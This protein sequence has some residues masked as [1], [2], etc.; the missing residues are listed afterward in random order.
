MGILSDPAAERAVIAGVCKYGSDI[1]FDICD[2]ISPDTFT[3]DSNMVL[4]QCVAK[5]YKDDDKSKIDVPIILSTAKDLGLSVVLNTPEELKHLNSILKFPV[6]IVNVKKL[7]A[8]V[9]KL[10]VARLA[11]ERLEQ[12]KDQLLEV[13]GTEKVSEILSIL[14]IDFSSFLNE[15]GETTVHIADDIDAFIQNLMDNPVSQIGI[16]TGFKYWDASIGGG[17]RKGTLN[18]IGARTKV[19]KSIIQQ[20]MALHIASK[21]IPVLYL[22]T[23]MVL[24][25]HRYRLYANMSGVE[26]NDVET[27]QFGKNT[28]DKLKVFEARDKSKNIPY[29]YQNISGMPFEEHLGIM[30]RWLMKNVGF[31]DDGSAKDCVIMYDYL[32]L[33]TG[34]N[35]SE[36]MKEYQLLGFMATGL[37]NFS[38]RYKLPIVATIQ[39]NRDGISKESTDAA[40]GSDRIAW[41]CSN[42]TI[43]KPKADEEV[44]DD[45]PAQGNRKLVT[46]IC[47]HGPGLDYGDYINVRLEGSI[48]RMTEIGLKSQISKR[49]FE[50]EDDSSIISD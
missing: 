8:K 19:G 24:E 18:V 33:M 20:N 49:E 31:N 6:E 11:F 50:L 4:W 44:A 42:F 37:H 3:I 38:V 35:I 14:E 9:R 15:T 22:D 7:A 17:L 48:A 39:L 28:A 30:R 45:G 34:D 23:E 47:R 1:Y 10:Q 36:D 5:I 43:L 27:G 26:I 25:E 21:G 46:V 41:L 2:I 16:G 12:A 32:K 13:K 40:S 29:F